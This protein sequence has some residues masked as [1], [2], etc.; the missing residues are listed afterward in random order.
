MA[1]SPIYVILGEQIGYLWIQ[2]IMGVLLLAI[3]FVERKNLSKRLL[4]G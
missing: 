3:I 2:V 1:V 4:V